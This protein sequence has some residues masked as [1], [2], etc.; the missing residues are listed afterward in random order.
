MENKNQY[1]APKIDRIELDNEISLTLDSLPPSG[2]GE[3]ASNKVPE[4][5][6]NDPFKSNQV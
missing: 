5:L 2:P 4:Y 1:T 3:G 6:N